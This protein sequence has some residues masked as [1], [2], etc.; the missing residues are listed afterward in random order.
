MKIKSADR[1]KND[2]PICLMG[3]LLSLILI[4]SS[5][6]FIRGMFLSRAAYGN[7]IGTVTTS[8]MKLV[9]TRGYTSK[10]ADIEYKYEVRN[11]WYY[12]KNIIFW[13]PKPNDKDFEQEILSHY[14]LKSRVIVYYQRNYPQFAVLNPD[15]PAS[16]KISLSVL[17]LIFFL[18]VLGSI[19]SFYRL[20]YHRV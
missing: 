17:L 9:V 10:L 12:S 19:W 2:L 16:T 18:S 1:H 5:R 11:N 13:F 20:Y 8:R 7:V 6:N 3:L 4:L 15:V 14:P